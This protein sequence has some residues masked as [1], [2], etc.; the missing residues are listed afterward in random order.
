MHALERSAHVILNEKNRKKKVAIVGARGY[1][2]LELARI[3]LKHPE[4]ELAACFA[5]DH[6][7]SL[8]DYLT[9]Q[10]AETVPVFPLRS[11]ASMLPNLD[12]VFLA[13]PAEGS[14]EL[15]PLILDAP[16]TQANVIDLSGAFRFQNGTEAER[17]AKFELWYKTKHPQQR[18]ATFGLAPFAQPVKAGKALIAN[19]G[20]Y[21]TAALMGIIP[22]LK[23]ATIQPQTLVIDAKSGTTGAGRKAA[24]SQLFAEVEGECLPYKI[25]SHQ[26]LPE[27]QEWAETFT[28]TKI[29]PFFTTHLLPV[30]RG[31]LASIY[32]ELAPGK[33][34]H[35]VAAAF[36]QAYKNYPLARINGANALSLK[37]VAGSA[38]TH[39]SYKVSGNKLYLFSLIDN[40]LKGAASQA[41]ENFNVLHDYPYALGLEA[42]EGTL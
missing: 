30:R 14:L 37:K 17:Q 42:L 4:T 27:I 28:Q 25:A 7:F 29:D 32:A 35:D 13:T 16:N 40:L 6:A 24:E 31:I 26:H 38:R 2:G 18:T 36:N 33:I 23:A 8:S 12:T 15:A 5:H 21:A 20:C 10:A 22:L 1:S 11:L 34:E 39:L 9:E 3:L 19:P 41:V